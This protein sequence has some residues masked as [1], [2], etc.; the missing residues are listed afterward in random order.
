MTDRPQNFSNHRAIPPT[1]FIV[2]VLILAAN[3]VVTGV[4]AVRAP[5]LGSVWGVL[6][7]LAI[8]VGLVLARVLVQRMQDRIIRLEMHVRLER[9][10]PAELRSEIPKLKLSQL[11]GLRF[12]NDA[13]LPALTTRALREGLTSEQI[14]RE[15][16]DWQADW[17]RV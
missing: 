15:V 12:A 11:V 1:A 5:S 3:V 4:Y 9:V 10:L 17:L 13:E 6:A 14:K 2:V 8:V 16:K 7:A